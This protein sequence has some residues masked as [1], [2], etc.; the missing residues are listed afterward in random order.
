MSP[1][2]CDPL[3]PVRPMPSVQRRA[4]AEHWCGSK[5][6]SVATTAMTEPDPAGR[7][8]SVS[9]SGLSSSR[10]FPTGCPAM[11]S[12][13]RGPKLACTNA[14]TVQVPEPICTSREAV[15]LPPL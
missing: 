10:S 9:A 14:P 7:N 8:Q 5:G 11:V 15:P 6:A 1:E 3:V 13:L 2:L 12:C 4:R